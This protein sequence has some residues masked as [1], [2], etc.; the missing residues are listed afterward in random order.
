MKQLTIISGPQGSGKSKLALEITGHRKAVIINNVNER[1]LKNAM[2]E[3]PEV[4]ILD[5]ATLP[6]IELLSHYIQK[7]Q[8]TYRPPYSRDQVTKTFPAVIACTNAQPNI[9]HIVGLDIEFIS[10]KP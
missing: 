7:Q 1:F 3:N 10:L 9:D 5:E 6:K 2:A 8:F 4:I